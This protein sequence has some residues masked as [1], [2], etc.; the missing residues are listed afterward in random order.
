MVSTNTP[1]VP[2]GPTAE[3]HPD[4]LALLRTRSY[5]QLLLLAASSALRSLRPRISSTTPSA[6]RR[7]RCSSSP[8]ISALIAHP[9]GGRF[10]CSSSPGSSWDS[11]FA[12]S[13][14]RAA[15]RRRWL[16]G[17]RQSIAS[18]ASRCASRGAC[19]IGS[20]RCP[21]SRGAAHCARRRARG[22]GGEA[23]KAR[24]V[25]DGREGDRIGRQFRRDQRALG[26]PLLSAFLLMEASG[27]ADLPWASGSS[28]MLAAGIGS[29]IFIGLDS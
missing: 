20:R 1:A 26:S 16:P 7:T 17:R 9:S 2:E 11:W 5:V 22:D 24:R 23:C 8:S 27:S 12:I 18:P 6:G 13:R 4:P 21:R 19:R 10:R 15:T 28:G 25:A 14:E 29:L 3:E